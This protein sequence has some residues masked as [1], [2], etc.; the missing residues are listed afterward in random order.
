MLFWKKDL[1]AQREQSAKKLRVALLEG[2]RGTP[3]ERLLRN[4]PG[5]LVRLNLHQSPGGGFAAWV[6][7]AD[8]QVLGQ[9]TV[10]P[11]LSAQDVAQLG[12]AAVLYVCLYQ[13][14]SELRSINKKL[15]AIKQQM[16]DKDASEFQ[17]VLAYCVSAIDHNDK[18]ALGRGELNLRTSLAA[19]AKKLV[20]EIQNLPDIRENMFVKMGVASDRKAEIAKDLLEQETVLQVVFTGFSTLIRIWE[21]TSKKPQNELKSFELQELS[22]HLRLAESKAKMVMART[23]GAE[24][25][26]LAAPAA[27]REVS[28]ASPWSHALKA[29][30]VANSYFRP[31]HM[32]FGRQSTLIVVPR[33]EIT[34][35]LGPEMAAA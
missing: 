14:A 9:A 21:I 32:G 15:A 4:A 6:R 29:V 7:G 26:S 10:T 8:G 24:G 31:E 1:G 2:I 23:N 16:D 27:L 13:I 30:D 3:L 25:V 11:T 12:A 22:T 5:E 35:I 19:Q 33:Q 34:E 28:L 17:Q 20:R 18:Q